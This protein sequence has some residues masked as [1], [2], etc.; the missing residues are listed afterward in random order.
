MFRGERPNKLRASWFS[1]KSIE[2]EPFFNILWG[3]ALHGC[4]G[5][6]ALPF[7]RKLRIRKDRKRR[8]A[9]GAKVQSREGNSPDYQLRSLIS[10]LVGKE[11]YEQNQ[12]RGG[13]R[14]SHPAKESVTAH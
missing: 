9:L 10:F 8:Q 6:K 7:P 3:R 11:Q 14:G 13:L 4:G 1:P 2:V 5:R 12:L